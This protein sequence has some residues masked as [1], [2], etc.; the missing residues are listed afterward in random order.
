MSNELKPCPMCGARADLHEDEEVCVAVICAQCDVQTTW[1]KPGCDE[2]AV[3]AWN[4]RAPQW[5]GVGESLPE[6]RAQAYQV[7][8][9]CAKEYDKDSMYGGKGVRRFQQD[10][11]VR[12]WPQN[13]THW[14]E[15]M[16][17][18]KEPA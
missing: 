2:D 13:F 5:I 11:V 8:V 3:E 1:Y 15:A 16:P 7:I 6:E 9:V 18:P 10:W 4:W 14:M 17:W 12:Q